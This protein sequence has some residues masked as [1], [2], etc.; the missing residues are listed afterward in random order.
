MITDKPNTEHGNGTNTV[1]PAVAPTLTL[2]TDAIALALRGMCGIGIG[3]KIRL[4]I[5]FSGGETSA[6]LAHWILNNLSEYFEIIIVFANTG[7]EEEATLEFVRD[8]DRYLGF[9]TIWVESVVHHGERKGSTYKF[10]NFETASRNGGPFEEVIKK[11]GIPNVDFPHCT[12]ELK[13]NPIHACAKDVFESDDYKTA[14]GIR[15]DEA[16]RIKNGKYWYPLLRM[17]ITKADIKAFW[18]SMPFR[19]SLNEEFLP[20]NLDGYRGNCKRCWKKTLTKL[21]QYTRDF[22]EDTW[23][24]D[25]EKKYEAFVPDGQTDGRSVPIRFNRK[26]MSGEEIRNL[27]ALTD[28]EIKER[29]SKRKIKMDLSN[30][31][32]ESCEVF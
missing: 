13:T 11:Y 5:S 10:V 6:F 7:R 23:I 31:C 21:I 16:D 15:S 24:E 26:N 19:L 22:P 1:L 2:S 20:K 17:G 14:I 4:L 18:K 29:M 28:K 27:S 32:S 25:M 3:A 30:G 8:C 12:R 9:K